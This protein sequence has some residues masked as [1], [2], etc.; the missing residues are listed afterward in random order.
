MLEV[1]EPGLG[2]A[3]RLHARLVKGQGGGVRAVEAAAITQQPLLLRAQVLELRL[4]ELNALQFRG[5]V[6]FEEPV[7]FG[8]RF[9]EAP[10][11]LGEL[12]RGLMHGLLGAF[13]GLEVRPDALG[14]LGLGEAFADAFDPCCVRLPGRVPPPQLL[15]LSTARVALLHL[16]Q[17]LLGSHEPPVGFGLL[18]LEPRDLLTQG[19]QPGLV[20]LLQAA[21]GA[22]NPLQR[23]LRLFK[24][25]H[26]AFAHRGHALEAVQGR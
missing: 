9:L 15:E 11:G 22:L 25:E 18:A 19:F 26:G 5:V 3:Q 7:A 17:R 20:G 14:P 2:F 24:V 6:R 8:A 23:A 4:A 13:E 16:L 10:L 21:Q 12:A 1:P